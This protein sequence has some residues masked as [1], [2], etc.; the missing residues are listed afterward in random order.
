MNKNKLKWSLELV[1]W[2]VTL[3]VAATIIFPIWSDMPDFPFFSTNFI[4]VISMITLTRYIFLLEHTFMARWLIFKIALIFLA[5][6]IVFLLV[7]EVNYFQ[8]YLDENGFE[9]FIKNVT[10]TQQ[11]SL[12]TYVQSEMLFFGVGSVIAGL[13][14]PIRMLISVWRQYNLD[15]V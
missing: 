14:L 15:K 12:A 9:P 7:Q 5:I 3:V 11:R 8:T 6:P 1:W 4:F 10:A 13:A 2:V